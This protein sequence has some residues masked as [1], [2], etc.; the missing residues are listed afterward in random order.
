MLKRVLLL[1]A[2]AMLSL[3]AAATDP[4]VSFSL[5]AKLGSVVLPPGLYKLKIQ[6][7]LAVLIDT[8]TNKSYPALV[9][10]EKTDKRSSYTAVQGRSADGVQYVSTIVLEGADYKLVF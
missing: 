3:A 9:K 8:A 2:I 5:P 10:I 4:E 6:G 7:A 1:F